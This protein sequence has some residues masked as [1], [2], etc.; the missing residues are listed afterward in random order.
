MNKLA[1]HISNE[2]THKYREES[3]G[4]HVSERVRERE[5]A[6][7]YSNIMPTDTRTIPLLAEQVAGTMKCYYEVFRS[8]NTCIMHFEV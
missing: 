8:R 4:G 3:V 2:N 7:K 6:N 1:C 5:R